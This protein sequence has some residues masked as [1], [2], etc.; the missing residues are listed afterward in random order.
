MI[1]SRL[2]R[3]GTPRSR[4]ARI[5]LAFA[6]GIVSIGLFAPAAQAYDMTRHIQNYATGECLDS[7]VNG[8]VYMLPCQDGNDWQTWFVHGSLG[9]EG[10]YDTVTIQ[11]KKTGRYLSI[12]SYL[13]CSV[14]GACWPLPKVST[15]NGTG[16]PTTRITGAGV[17]WWKVT[18][19]VLRPNSPYYCLEATA[20]TAVNR[21]GTPNCTY[22]SNQTWRLI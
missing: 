7:N 14:A 20:D 12:S 2:P 8:D 15:V 5:C 21:F 18:L 13:F 3:R 10:G 1:T 22:S 4:L 17:G 11:N 16:D 6:L 9:S 19:R